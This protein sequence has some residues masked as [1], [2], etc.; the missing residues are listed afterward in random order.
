MCCF[1]KGWKPMEELHVYEIDDSRYLAIVTVLDYEILLSRCLKEIKFY[2]TN[3]KIIVDLA[4][5]SGIDR[6]RFVEFTIDK[7]GRILTG[8]NSYVKP[9]QLL[10]DKANQFLKEN[11]EIVINSFL[12]ESR[13]KELLL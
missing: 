5:K 13:K 4:L 12:P 6:Y 10:V 3:K 8:S 7:N 2:P 11:K 1:W 9:K